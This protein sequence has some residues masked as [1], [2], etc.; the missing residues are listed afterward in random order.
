M[1]QSREARVDRLLQISADLQKRLAE[2]QSLRRAVREA[3]AT[4]SSQQ[5][6]DPAAGAPAL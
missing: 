5:P 4:Q 3:E 1:E 2:V 6:T